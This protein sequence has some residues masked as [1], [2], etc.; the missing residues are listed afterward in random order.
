[1]YHR[2]GTTTT[3][4][5]PDSFSYLAPFATAFSGNGYALTTDANGAPAYVLNPHVTGY[6][7]ESYNAKIEAAYAAKDVK[8]R[9]TLLHEA[10][11]ML[12]EDMPVIPIVYNQNVS[13]CSGKLSR[14]DSAFFCNAVFKEVKLSGYWKIALRDEFTKPKEEE[15]T[16]ESIS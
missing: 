14:V 12:M 1:M 13:L 3:S 4:D 16:F 10:E 2:S 5:S 9:T 15:D 11:A 8:T 6:N 7:S